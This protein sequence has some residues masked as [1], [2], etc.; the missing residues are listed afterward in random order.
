MKT[1]TSQIYGDWSGCGDVMLSESREGE[2]WH[3]SLLEE[4]RD[5][6]RLSLCAAKLEQGEEQG[7]GVLGGGRESV[8]G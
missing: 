8:S 1:F 6:R 5:S 3:V 7:H 2:R 4:Q